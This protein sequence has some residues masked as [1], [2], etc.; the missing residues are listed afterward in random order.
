MSFL[1][2]RRAGLGRLCVSQALGLLLGIYESLPAERSEKHP[3]GE[4]RISGICSCFSTLPPGF[5]STFVL[6]SPARATLLPLLACNPPNCICKIHRTYQWW[7]AA[8]ALSEIASCGSWGLDVPQGSRSASTPRCTHR[9][10]ASQQPH[11][12]HKIALRERKSLQQLLSVFPERTAL[13]KY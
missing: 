5:C 2:L 12:R 3:M 6:F 1:Q 7:F 9:S 8:S 13:Q 11:G 10:G 4:Q